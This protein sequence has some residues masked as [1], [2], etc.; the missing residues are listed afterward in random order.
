M[1]SRICKQ[2][3]PDYPGDN[4]V[5]F[6]IADPVYSRR[7]TFG[8]MQSGE[9]YSVEVCKKT[10]MGIGFKFCQH[11]HRSIDAAAKCAKVLLRSLR[12]D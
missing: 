1:V 5:A 8:D 4:Y 7:G 12:R 10:D 6:V 2:V 9:T 11:N 3:D